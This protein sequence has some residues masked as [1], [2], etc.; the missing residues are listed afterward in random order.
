MILEASYGVETEG[1]KT[2]Q[3]ILE[4]DLK[5]ELDRLGGQV[6]GIQ[7]K[8][9]KI[10]QAGKGCITVAA[11]SPK[12]V[13]IPAMSTTLVRIPTSGHYGPIKLTVDF[14]ARKEGHVEAY[15]HSN[16][17]INSELY[18]GGYIWKFEKRTKMILQPR[19]AFDKSL[20]SEKELQK[21]IDYS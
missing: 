12:L 5:N 4:I 8:L 11:Q 13:E 18:P 19:A 16:Q 7:V 3:N 20:L 9:H 17:N 15:L 2:K 10:V 6:R 21:E 1:K 14:L